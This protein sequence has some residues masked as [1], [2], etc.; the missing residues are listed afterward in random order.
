MAEEV[1]KTKKKEVSIFKPKKILSKKS[2][3]FDDYLSQ[4]K[5]DPSEEKEIR[6]KS[7]LRT[8]KDEA[9]GLFKLGEIIKKILEWNQ[10]TDREIKEKKKEILLANYFS[11]TEKIGNS[12]GQLKN[13]LTD[14]FGNVIFNKILRI[15]DNTPPDKELLYHLSNV[16]KKVVESK[17]FRNLFGKHK[18]VLSQIEKLSPQALTILSDYKNWPHFKM[19][20]FTALGGRIESDWLLAFITPY[21]EQKGIPIGGEERIRIMGALNELKQYGFIEA[22]LVRGEI[23]VTVGTLV[24]EEQKEIEVIRTRAGIEI[25]EYLDV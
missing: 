25:T 1:K 5:I 16:L 11:K 2:K 17:D 19:K 12:V 14:P 4:A 23:D 3:D 15:I 9:L 8:I 10:K 21:A 7:L 6:K 20:S 24:K 22:H 13:F 18:Y